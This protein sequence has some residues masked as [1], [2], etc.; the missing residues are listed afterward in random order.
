M[1]L[2][3]E[4]GSSCPPLL[5]ET[6]NL[7]QILLN[8]LSG[9]LPVASGSTVWLFCSAGLSPASY[10]FKQGSLRRE[11]CCRDTAH[12]ELCAWCSIVTLMEDPHLKTCENKALDCKVFH[13]H[14]MHGNEFTFWSVHPWSL[15]AF[16]GKQ[17]SGVDILCEA[18]ECRTKLFSSLFKY[19]NEGEDNVGLGFFGFLFFCKKLKH[20]HI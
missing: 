17:S 1:K 20:P 4:L 11:R 5:V 19:I 15:P 7:C 3:P 6:P 14:Y 10:P 16:L 12:T 2:L 13:V 9:W 8:C 18:L